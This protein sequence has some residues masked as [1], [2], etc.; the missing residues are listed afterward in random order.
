M[1]DFADLFIST[2]AKPS[3]T[4]STKKAATEEKDPFDDMMEEA[5]QAVEEQSDA[6]GQ[7][8]ES[9]KSTQSK[10]KIPLQQTFNKN[11]GG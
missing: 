9:I 4:S 6:G 11:Q 1:L 8:P 7:P 5:N 2:G 10:P 3:F